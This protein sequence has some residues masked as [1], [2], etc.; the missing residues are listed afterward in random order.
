V[1]PTSQGKL[2]PKVAPT[3]GRRHAGIYDEVKQISGWQSDMRGKS[4]GKSVKGREGLAETAPSPRMKDGE[5]PKGGV[6]G[7]GASRS[8]KNWGDIFANIGK[9]VPVGV[10]LNRTRA[11]FSPR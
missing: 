10:D 4:H 11:G 5:K 9:R 6:G 2:T 3:Q 8:L 7:G 1:N